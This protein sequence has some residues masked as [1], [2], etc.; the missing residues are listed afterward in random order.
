MQEWIEDWQP[1]DQ[2]HNCSP[3]F[4]IYPGSSV[5]LRGTPN[6]ARAILKWMDPRHSRGGW[7]LAWDISRLGTTGT[8]R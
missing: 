2:G 3:N 7:P 6:L 4:T 8:G 5:T 1:G